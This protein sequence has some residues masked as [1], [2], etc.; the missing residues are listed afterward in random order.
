MAT[1][2]I[3]LVSRAAEEGVPILGVSA[4]SGSTDKDR[5]SAD[6]ADYAAMVSQ[7]HGCWAEAEVFIRGQSSRDVLFE[8][9]LGDD[10]VEAV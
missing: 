1:D 4:G 10:P 5:A 9:V 8:I 3:R 7:G 2:A 6:R